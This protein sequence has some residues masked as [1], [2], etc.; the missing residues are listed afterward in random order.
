MSPSLV[1][2]PERQVLRDFLAFNYRGDGD[3]VEIG[4]FCGSSAIAIMQGIAATR[5]K[6]KLFVYDTFLFPENDLERKYRNHT[7]L[8]KGRSF[9]EEFDLQTRHWRDE[10]VVVQ[11]DAATK[12]WPGVPIEFLHIDCS[13]SR[14]FHEA[15]A[16][17]F[18]P[19][20]MAG[21]VIAHQDY[22]YER[23]PFIAEIMSS[24]GGFKPLLDV[25]TSR[26]FLCRQRMRREEIAVALAP[27]MAN[28]A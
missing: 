23:A 2:M 27:R 14:E 20:V 19:H 11:G 3:V 28:A 15:I 9:R 10:M 16:L 4:A 26:Y 22:G 17:E 8:L 5:H 7:P 24:L 12:K 1:S 18:Y 13:V 6:R 25:E 21:G